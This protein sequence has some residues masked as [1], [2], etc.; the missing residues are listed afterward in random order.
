[1]TKTLDLKRI[2]LFADLEAGELE[3]LADI[4]VPRALRRG[5]TLF[6]EGEPS[7]GFFAV[8]DGLLKLYKVAPEGREQVLHLVGP[9]QTFAEASMFGEGCYPASAEAIQPSELWLVP[10]GP[11]LRLLRAEPELAL[12]MLA[13][14]AAWLKRLSGLVE[15]LSLKN[16][17]ARLAEYL[18]ARAREEGRSTEEGLLLTLDL[19]KRMVAAHIGTISETLSRTLKKLKE[20]GLIREEGSQILIT[21]AEGLQELA[22]G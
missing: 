1:M 5:E 14:M 12:K 16:V 15:T 17:E 20:K 11:F 19:E 7:D 4:V 18:L 9:G 2:F 3:R 8:A 6:F 13:S 10:K 21:D 22:E